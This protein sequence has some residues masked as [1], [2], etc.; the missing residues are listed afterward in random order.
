MARFLA[1]VE[2]L[3]N[4]LRHPV[5][6]FALIALLIVIVSAIAHSAGVSVQDPRPG[7]EGQALTTQ[8]LLD[9]DGIAWMS[10]NLVKNFTNFAP[11]GT[12]LV[13]PLGVGVAEESGLLSAVIR[14]MILS[15]PKQAATDVVVIAGG[16]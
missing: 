14:K 3:G 9:G 12:V 2:W 5:T 4:L 7:N 1:F 10:Q 16:S 11:L 13:A 8:S 15:A 6:L